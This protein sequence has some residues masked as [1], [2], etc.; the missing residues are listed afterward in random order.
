MATVTWRDETT[1]AGGARRGETWYT[2]SD[3]AVDDLEAAH[4]RGLVGRGL[5]AGVTL[6]SPPWAAYFSGETPIEGP[7]ATAR[8][9][10]LHD[11]ASGLRAALRPGDIVGEGAARR[12]VRSLFAYEHQIT[13]RARR[14]ARASLWARDRPGEAL[15]PFAERVAWARCRCARCCPPAAPAP[16]AAAGGR[17]DY[18]YTHVGPGVGFIY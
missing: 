7:G 15:P 17:V 16:M 5:L 18:R 10:A 1:M 9:I 4:L 12:A 8:W 6:P 3:P 13:A 2:T 14:R 11:R